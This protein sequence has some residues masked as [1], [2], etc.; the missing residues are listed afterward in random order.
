MK[1]IKSQLL[2]FER[3]TREPYHYFRSYYDFQHWSPDGNYLLCHR[4]P[5]RDRLQTENDKAELG[6][7]RMSDY[8]FIPVAETYAWNFQQGAMLQW[9]P[10]N[11]GQ[12]IIYNTRLNGSY[13]A[14]AQNIITG[15][16]R[17]LPHP[18]RS[19]S[20]D[21]KY[22]LCIN[23]SRLF[24]QRPGYGYAGIPDPFFEEQ[25]PKEDG[26][27][28]MELE[29]GHARLIISVDTVYSLL[30]DFPET[31]KNMKFLIN[32]S[33]FNTDSSRFLLLI[34]NI[35]PKDAARPWWKTAA[36]TANMDGSELHVLKDFSMVSHNNWRDSR[37]LLVYWEEHGKNALCLI[38]DKTNK[39]E[40][41]DPEFFGGDGHCS[42]SPDKRFI[43]YDSYPDVDGYKKLILYDIERKHGIILAELLD[44]PGNC[45][46]ARC[47][48]HPSW[49]RDGTMIC[50]DSVHEGNR[51]IY[52]MDI[53]ELIKGL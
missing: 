18:V 34:R 40:I 1:Q 13:K 16:T 8:C 22:A 36:L 43:L 21:G 9:N 3:I 44:R 17:I 47:D 25:L 39:T 24:D 5:F 48:L 29:S 12:E 14:V 2:P 35:P 42:Y 7:I 20:Q 27:F 32:A 37:H 4:T 51:H 33:T 30:S 26:V 6:I 15:E 52:Q 10:A 28:L 31:E 41:V 46:D 23:Y 38:E 45:V 53:T 49:N 19:I 50:F 11:A